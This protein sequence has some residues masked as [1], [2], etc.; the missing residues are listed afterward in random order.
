[1]RCSVHSAPA[2]F[3]SYSKDDEKWLDVILNNRSV[4]GAALPCV[5][6]PQHPSRR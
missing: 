5:D 2:V 1:M 4:G 3:V 6:G